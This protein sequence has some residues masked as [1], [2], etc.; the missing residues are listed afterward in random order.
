MLAL[1]VIFT[2]I[3]L[4]YNPGHDTFV[5]MR[6]LLTFLKGIGIVDKK[7]RIESA[8]ELK[9]KQK[10]ILK[11][12]DN[13]VLVILAAHVVCIGWHFLAIIEDLFY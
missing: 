9:N 7:I 4:V 6:N 12:V 5:Y 3:P 10:H 13:V 11:L 8:I 1:K 2:K